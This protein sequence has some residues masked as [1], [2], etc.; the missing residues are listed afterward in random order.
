MT[1]III[2]FLVIL[3]ALAWSQT[4]VVTGVMGLKFGSTPLQLSALAKSKGWV[5]DVNSSSV[6]TK[7]YNTVQVAERNTILATF[8]FINGKLYQ[9]SFYFSETETKTIGLYDQISTELND[10]Y[11]EPDCYKLFKSPFKEGDGDEIKAIKGGYAEYECYWGMTK[12]NPNGVNLK[13]NSSLLIE[14]KYQDAK[15][16]KEALESQRQK[17]KSDY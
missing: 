16:I 5:F 7:V 14:L 3:P 1:K 13:I 8:D 10:V 17:K 11:G 9:A 12:S 6:K 4:K 2:T 15:L